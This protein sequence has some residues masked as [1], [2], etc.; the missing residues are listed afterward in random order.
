MFARTKRVYYGPV[1]HTFE[2]VLR[3]LAWPLPHQTVPSLR[4]SLHLSS[5]CVI[6]PLSCDPHVLNLPIRAGRQGKLP[7]PRPRKFQT[8]NLLFAEVVTLI[9][10]PGPGTSVDPTTHFSLRHQAR[11]GIHHCFLALLIPSHCCRLTLESH[12]RT[13]HLSC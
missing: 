4:S 2:T 5:A 7:P 11:P 9:F 10:L 6:P 12:P 13:R 8:S 1:R 3:P